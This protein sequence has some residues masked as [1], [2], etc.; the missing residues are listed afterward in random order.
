[1]AALVNCEYYLTSEDQYRDDFSLDEIA[2]KT[3]NGFAYQ[4]LF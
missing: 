1:M 2:N 3:V 4:L